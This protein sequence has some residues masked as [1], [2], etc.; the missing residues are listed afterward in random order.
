MTL[1]F[2]Q[3]LFLMMVRKRFNHPCSPTTTTTR[4]SGKER[5]QRKWTCL[6]RVLWS[7]S[8]LRCLE[9]GSSAHR[10]AAA[11]A[12]S[13]RKCFM[14]TPAVQLSSVGM[15]N[16]NQQPQIS[17]R[18]QSQQECQENF[19]AMPLSGK[20]RSEKKQDQQALHSEL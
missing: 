7:H 15:A 3:I 2:F 10:S 6:E 1:I 4:G 14:D 17:R 19:S 13:P 18:D 12:G 5:I 11:A 20:R 9:L 16:T 8:H